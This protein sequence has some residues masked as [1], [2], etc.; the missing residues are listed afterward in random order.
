MHVPAAD[1]EPARTVASAETVLA[2]GRGRA[3]RTDVE[4]EDGQSRPKPRTRRGSRGGRNRKRKVPVGGAAGNGAEPAADGVAT[5]T[6]ASRSSSQS[7]EA[8][9]RRSSRRRPPGPPGSPA[10]RTAPAAEA[11]GEP[12]YTPMSE[13]LDDFD[14]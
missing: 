13:W 3:G 11:D 7:A 5:A 8:A 6:V 9:A 1:L 4:A 14:R 12:G 2:H 10:P